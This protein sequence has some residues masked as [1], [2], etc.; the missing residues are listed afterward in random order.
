MT[1]RNLEETEAIHPAEQQRDFFEKAPSDPGGKYLQADLELKTANDDGD[2]PF[3]D[4]FDLPD[5]F[6]GGH[7]Q[8][9]EVPDGLGN[10]RNVSAGIDVE[11]L[12]HTPTPVHHIDA[13][14]RTPDGTK[15][16]ASLSTEREFYLH[17]R[18]S[19]NVS[20]RGSF[21]MVGVE[22]G[23]RR[24]ACRQTVCA[25]DP[26]AATLSPTMA[27]YWPA[28]RERS[29]RIKKSNSLLKARFFRRFVIHFSPSGKLR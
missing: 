27:T 28:K 7:R 15:E 21:P 17:K 22:E 26:E 12:R 14:Y 4:P 29:A 16:V 1:E 19:T 2:S 3:A 18:Q 20:A 24:L 11:K 6:W 25:L 5:L 10:E 8:A 9:Q 23:N 13:G